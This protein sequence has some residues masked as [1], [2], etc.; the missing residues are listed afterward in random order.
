MSERWQEQEQR[1][2]EWI[3]SQ[4]T[5]AGADNEAVMM[6]FC[7]TI[8]AAGFLANALNKGGAINDMPL[9]ERMAQS[10][11]RASM[12]GEPEPHLRSAMT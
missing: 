9:L 8:T 2:R 1:A 6:V 4:I 10:W 11:L 5:A 12:R 7:T 3:S